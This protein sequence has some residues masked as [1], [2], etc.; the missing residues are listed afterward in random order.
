MQIDRG[1]SVIPD[2]LWEYGIATAKAVLEA[3]RF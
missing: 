3:V 1:T 2:E